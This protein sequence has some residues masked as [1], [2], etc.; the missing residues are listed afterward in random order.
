MGGQMANY[1]DNIK[2][3]LLMVASMA[4]F[5]FNDVF[6]K[7]LGADLPLFQVLMLR[8]M[9]TSFCI[10][11][12]CIYFKAWTFDIALKDWRLIGLRSLG[13][14]GASYFF[15]TALFN[16]PLANATAILQLLPL[17]VAVGGLL[18]FQEVIGWRRALA[19]A[20]GFGGMF[21]IVR[22]G[23]EGFNHYSFYALIAVGFV[24]LRDLVTRKID[25]EVPSLMV[26]FFNAV[27]ICLY[28][29]LAMFWVE[30]VPVGS[31]NAAYL[32]TA[33]FLV[34]AAYLLSVL[35][36]RQ[37]EVS[38][39]APFRYTGLIWA[40]VLGWIFFDHWP[41]TLTLIG[42][43]VIVMSGL[44]TMWRETKTKSRTKPL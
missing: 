29:S 34:S 19:I 42:A 38:F 8:G 25:R 22:P 11:L 9:L 15:L 27:S 35:V 40:L 17:T 32:V 4:A 26:T 28:S 3:A 21:L 44:F 16:M 2:G 5:T 18:F 39:V 37:G 43:G 20:I 6:V 33:A 10:F 7:L 13:D 14:I 30:W 1:S 36:M 41:D 24:T 31:T 23:I 12:L